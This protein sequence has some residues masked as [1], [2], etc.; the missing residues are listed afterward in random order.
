[1]CKK[2]TS[3]SHSSTESEIISLDTGLR[4]DGLPALELW[5][6][7]VSVFGNISHIS[8]RTGK[9]VN[10]ENKHHKSHNKIDVMQD[11]DSVPSHVQS[12]RQEAVLYVFEDKEAVIKLIMKGRSPT[13][14]HVSRTHRVALDWLFDRMNLDPKIQIKYIDTKHQL[15][16][17]LTK[18]NFT[19]D[20]WNHLLTLFNISHFSSTA[21]ITAMAK[22]AQQESGEGRVTAKSR[23]MMNLT[24][25]TPSF[26]SS[27]ASSSPG[28]TS[29]GYQD[30]GKS[31]PSDDRSGKPENSS[32][33]G[34]SK[35]DY[36][37]SWSS[38]EWKSG[39][40]AHDRSGKPE[41]NSWDSLQK[42][43]PHREESLLG[44]KCAFRKVRR[45]DSRWN[46]ETCVR[47]S[48]RTGSFGKFRHGQ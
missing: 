14:R 20:E 3:V 27:A 31:V 29:Y 9:P 5:D 36:G 48:P 2:Q 42:V 47:E 45:D 37:R 23:P 19:R 15:A 7:I 24:A 30:P 33:P 12:V 26:V 41:Q 25:R 44:R 17:I 13:M 21:C 38:Q 10:G 1:M 32:P 28:R 11:I 39:A 8:V 35:E 16:D 43:D 40:V 4:L 22:R 34:Y 46:G 18:G 6:L